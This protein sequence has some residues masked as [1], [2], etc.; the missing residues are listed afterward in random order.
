MP[1][2]IS[3]PPKYGGQVSCC[4]LSTDTCSGPTSTTFSFLVNE[5]PDQ[6]SI[7]APARIKM[8]PRFL[9]IVGCCLSMFNKMLVF[10]CLLTCFNVKIA[11]FVLK[12]AIIFGVR[13]V[14]P[15]LNLHKNTVKTRVLSCCYIHYVCINNTIIIL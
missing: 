6:M 7:T 11:F 1:P 3:T 2:T 15:G 14:F 9:F 13:I 8:M 12:K 4:L 5:I 10:S